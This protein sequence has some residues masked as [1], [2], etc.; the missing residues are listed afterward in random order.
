MIKKLLTLCLLLT[1]LVS[2]ARTEISTPLFWEQSIS[3]ALSDRDMFYQKLGVGPHANRLRDLLQRQESRNV[4]KLLLEHKQP[5]SPWFHFLFGLSYVNSDKDL[6]RKHFQR[7]LSASEKDAGSTWVLFIEFDIT[8]NTKWAEKSLM[9]LEKQKLLAGARSAPVISQQLLSL[10]HNG[11]AK[12]QSS[13]DYLKWSYR[14][15]RYPFWLQLTKR[16]NSPSLS[17]LITSNSFMTGISLLTKSWHFQLST[18]RYALMFLRFALIVFVCTV[19]LSLSIKTIP[20]TL[21]PLTELFPPAIPYFL[22]L[23]FSILVY[24]SLIAIGI[25]P[26]LFLHILL[27]WPFVR[28]R[29]RILLS[30]C[31]AVLL[32]GPLDAR[33]QNF[34]S[35]MLS[36]G[37]VVG[38]YH[39]TV[40]SGYSPELASALVHAMEQNPQDHLPYMS[41][42]ILSL[43]K[44]DIQT[45]L[46]HILLA[47]NIRPDDPVLQITTGNI[48]FAQGNL[49]KAGAYYQ[50]CINQFPEY[51]EGFFNLGQY[52]FAS[53]QTMR[54]TELVAQAADINESRVNEFIEVNDDKF[55]DEWPMIRKVMHADY[56]PGYFWSHIATAH[57]GNW[58]QASRIW[59]AQFLNLSP[60]F[61][62]VIFIAG[63][64]VVWYKRPRRRKKIFYCRLCERTMCKKC[65]NGSLCTDCVKK[66]QISRDESNEA[67][68][69]EILIRNKRHLVTNL[70]HHSLNGVFPGSGFLYVGQKKRL[71]ITLMVISSLVY[72]SYAAILN[73]NFSY[74]FWVI[75]P[76]FTMVLT[77]CL[78]YSLSFLGFQLLKA[79]KLLSGDK[80]HVI[81]R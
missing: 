13:V 30:A 1:P 34:F 78:L 64:F 32:C 52:S 39:Q 56:K 24:A 65:R 4:R 76:L 49:K 53:M 8:G 46:H 74:P 50:K 22:R 37:S 62:Y 47:E 42:A 23:S 21:H 27:S 6:V 61:L 57:S 14:F 43:K 59:S 70:I 36:P 7:A 10:A 81:E 20:S 35:T 41:A 31:L 80:R 51:E 3:Q 2:Q 77:V 38:L 54:G 67:R 45:A 72:A 71:S 63:A 15:E 55:A 12:K 11:N 19:V 18:F 16:N 26:F 60:V 17:T 68:K 44:G 69:A 9:Q 25:L 73:F 75:A 29:G 5:D 66:L 58:K 33:L 79:A 40:N 28:K 48:Y